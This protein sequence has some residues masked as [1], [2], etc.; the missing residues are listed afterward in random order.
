VGAERLTG[1]SEQEIIGRNGDVI[2]TPEDR[3]VG[4]PEKERSQALLSGRSENERWHRRKNG[5]QY[6][7]S[8]LMTPLRNGGGFVKI[9]RIGRRSIPA[10]SS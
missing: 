4:A 8:G 6:W 1:Y 7:G 5:T 9:M 3:T 10:I 2:F